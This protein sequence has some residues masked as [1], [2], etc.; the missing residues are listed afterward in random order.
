M[1]LESLGCAGA[2]QRVGRQLR[3]A[4]RAY[5]IPNLSRGLKRAANDFT[6]IRRPEYYQ[7]IPPQIVNG[8]SVRS[9]VLDSHRAHSVKICNLLPSS[10]GAGLQTTKTTETS[11]RNGTACLVFGRDWLIKL[12]NSL[13][14]AIMR[15]LYS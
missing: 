1:R 6:Q 11:D 12:A 14:S 9:L 13:V 4:G 10:P 2:S 5:G 7:R 3:G 15:L 8:W